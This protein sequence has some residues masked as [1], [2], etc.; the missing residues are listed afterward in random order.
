MMHSF[1]L[2]LIVLRNTLVV[3]PKGCALAFSLD[4]PFKL[5]QS[6]YILVE[7]PGELTVGCCLLV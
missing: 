3:L 1:D 6:L 2:G 5:P 7:I 4:N